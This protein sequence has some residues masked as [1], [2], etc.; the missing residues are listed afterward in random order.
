MPIID[1]L[2]LVVNNL[3]EVELLRLNKIL[4]HNLKVERTR[5]SDKLRAAL[6]V[7]DTVEFTGRERGRGGRGFPVVGAVSKIKR[8]RAEVTCFDKGLTW[9]VSIS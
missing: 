7:G 5:K 8:K 6:T 3:T 4:V 2:I 1:E 9:D